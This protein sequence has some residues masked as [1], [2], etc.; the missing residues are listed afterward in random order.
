MLKFNIK[1]VPVSIKTEI[2]NGTLKTTN[3]MPQKDSTSDNQSS[4]SM[5]RQAYNN[6]F[7]TKPLINTLKPSYYGMGGHRNPTIFDGTSSINQKKWKGNRDASEIVRK[8]RVTSIGL[9]SLN[10]NGNSFSFE[11]HANANTINHALSRVRGGGA[12]A[13]VKKAFNK[14]NAYTP[15]PK[16]IPFIQPQKIV[17]GVK[18]P[19]IK[20]TFGF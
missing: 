10:S 17:N 13:P 16:N 5:D 4:F 9:G 19:P 18:M 1:N 20:N 2:N 15:S 6:S 14:H 7:T 11:S 12:V 8:N 3:A